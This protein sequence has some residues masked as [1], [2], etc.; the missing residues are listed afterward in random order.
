MQLSLNCKYEFSTLN[1]STWR[2]QV[3]PVLHEQLKFFIIY[4]LDG[5]SDKQEANVYTCLL[6]NKIPDARLTRTQNHNLKFNHSYINK[7]V[8]ELMYQT[9]YCVLR[10]FFYNVQTA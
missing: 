5:T 3:K 4:K 10:L 2:Y 9:R 1:L 7:A 6:Y 8:S